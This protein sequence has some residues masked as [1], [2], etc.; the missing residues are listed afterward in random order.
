[1]VLP[2]I[3]QGFSVEGKGSVMRALPL[4]VALSEEKL[5]AQNRASS[6][7]SSRP[8]S[9][10]ILLAFEEAIPILPGHKLAVAIHENDLVCA[11]FEALAVV[12]KADFVP[13]DSDAGI[14]RDRQTDL[15]PFGNERSDGICL[16]K[17]F[18]SRPLRGLV[19]RRALAFLRDN[20][21]GF[22]LGS[23]SSTSVCAAG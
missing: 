9:H 2:I 18:Y 1:M 7:G 23:A 20:M 21:G 17:S 3:V 4:R 10:Q 22:N 14:I 8:C 6:A 12:P 19:S 13:E 11:V 16:R 15:P 5:P